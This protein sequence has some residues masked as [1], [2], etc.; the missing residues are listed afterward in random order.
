LTNALR[1]MQRA[2]LFLSVTALLLGCSALPAAAQLT[3]FDP[4]NQQ[5]NLLSAARALQQI[6]NQVRQL[7]GEAQMLARMEQNLVR[8]KGSISPDLQRTL[9]AINAHLQQGNAIALSL[10]AT[11]A[12]YARLF[13]PSPSP[14][15]SGDARLS[16]AR[17]RWAEEYASLERAARLQGEIGDGLAVD[18]TLL[19]DAMDRSRAAS[20]ALEV[21]QAGN[22]LTAL[23][24]KQALSLQSLL[25]TQQRAETLKAARELASEAEGRQRFKTFLGDTTRVAAKR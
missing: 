25:A 12:N 8:L 1:Q 9:T 15:L 11:E 4:A 10:K 6:N 17:Q 14:S 21:A 20:G 7:Q 3:V 2:S 18:G 24:V 16:A 13:P 19:R 23:S 5:A 22:E